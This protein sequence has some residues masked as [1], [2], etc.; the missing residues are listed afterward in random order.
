MW[1]LIASLSLASSGLTGP[2]CD[3]VGCLCFQSRILW[4]S[5][6]SIELGNIKVRRNSQVSP[7]FLSVPSSSLFL[8]MMQTSLS[9][10]SSRSFLTFRGWMEH[11]HC[12]WTEMCKS[13]VWP[14]PCFLPCWLTSLSLVCVLCHF[15]GNLC[16]REA[17]C[18]RQCAHP[19][20][21]SCSH[22]QASACR[23]QSL[24]KTNSNKIDNSNKINT[25]CFPLNQGILLIPN[26]N[27]V[28]LDH[29]D[30]EQKASVAHCD[31]RRLTGGDV[32]LEKPRR[33]MS[34]CQLPAVET[35]QSPC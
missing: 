28:L 4:V 3:T 32:L 24:H 9:A 17:P 15:V 16:Q 23:M 25:V 7:C 26:N 2:A 11:S 20:C 31:F 6:C 5:L 34:S 29:W 10:S 19:Q 21:H 22:A 35:P 14:S 18:L 27:Q 13:C 33:A 1:A 12:L 30:S 8:K